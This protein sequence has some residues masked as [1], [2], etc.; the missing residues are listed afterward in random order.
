ML[1]MIT[2]FI[3]CLLAAGALGFIVGWILSSLI[4][5]EKS[6]TKYSL[7]KEDYDTQR[8]ELNQA[9]TDLNAKDKEC[10]RTQNQVQRLEKELLTKNMDI[11][12][13]QQHGFISP[14]STDTSTLEL[15]NN[16]LKEEISE[17]KY[18]ENE[19]ELLHN[20]LKEL[21]IEKEKLIEDR[22]K[23]KNQ[24]LSRSRT[25][26][27]QKTYKEMHLKDKHI[28][29]LQSDLKKAKKKIKKMDTYLTQLSKENSNTKSKVQKDKKNTKPRK[30][31]PIIFDFEKVAKSVNSKKSDK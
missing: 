29:V 30:D 19:N 27:T 14:I 11:E 21:S 7:I 31:K 28:Q 22:D 5:N 25:Q 3:F 4:R 17:Y 9:Y 8:V 16:T 6:E 10:I 24:F 18:L 20:E 13:Y 1:W 12:E 23:Q 26:D 15:E 2:K